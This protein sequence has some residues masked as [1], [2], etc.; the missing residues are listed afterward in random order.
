VK[1]ALR[2]DSVLSGA[3]PALSP[4]TASEFGYRWQPLGSSHGRCLHTRGPAPEA[5]AAWNV[6]LPLANRTL[7]QR[8]LWHAARTT[9]SP[10]VV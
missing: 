2:H 1:A 3:D 5:Q 7:C 9:P 4:G 6:A 10:K 8:W